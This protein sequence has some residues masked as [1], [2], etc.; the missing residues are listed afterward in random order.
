VKL[1]IAHADHTRTYYT[2]LII[3]FE[4]LIILKPRKKGKMKN[5][6]KEDCKK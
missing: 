6:E 5:K 2:N 4:T 3:I 1:V